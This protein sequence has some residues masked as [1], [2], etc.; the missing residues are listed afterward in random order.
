MNVHWC[1]DDNP[2]SIAYLG[3]ALR[4]H[5][6]AASAVFVGLAVLLVALALHRAPLYKATTLLVL[7]RSQLELDNAKPTFPE[8]KVDTEV[9]QLRAMSVVRRVADALDASTVK[10]DTSAGKSGA[11]GRKVS[12]STDELTQADL[13]E[14]VALARQ[15][16]IRRHGLTDVVG[17]E[18][19]GATPEA[20]A[21]L[22][23]LYAHTFLD[24]QLRDKTD[25]ARRQEKSLLKRIE[26]LREGL[27]GPGAG[28]SGRKE[29]HEAVVELGKVQQRNELL[30]PDMK[31]LSSALPIPQKAFP[32]PKVLALLG[33]L[34]ALFAAVGC[35]VVLDIRNRARPRVEVKGM[36]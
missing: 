8:N 19:T 35:A 13:S 9:E 10:Q 24:G 6:R 5:W 4:E 33:I 16:R 1:P 2:F 27:S 28:L 20:A 26:R 30:A 29:F 25:V 18:A 11:E 31:M 12:G 22:A 36:R 3:D 21:N 17:I 34:V 7:D 15:V 14:L 32:S 23:N